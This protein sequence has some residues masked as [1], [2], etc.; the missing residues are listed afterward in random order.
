HL[1]SKKYEHLMHASEVF[2]G[3]NYQ[4]PEALEALRGSD[5]VSADEMHR[6]LKRWS[7][8]GAALRHELPERID[9]NFSDKVM[10]QLDADSA[11]VPPT[12]SAWVPPIESTRDSDL[13]SML[14]GKWSNP[15]PLSANSEHNVAHEYAALVT[16]LKAQRDAADFNA[17][18]IAAD[19]DQATLNTV[20]HQPTKRHPVLSFKRVGSWLGQAAVAAS[21]AVVAVV[22]VQLYNASQPELDNPVPTS[23]I[24]QV[25]PV[26]GLNLASYQNSDND[27]IMNPELMP[28]QPQVNTPEAQNKDLT[29]AEV[30]AE[31]KAELDRINLYVQGFMLE[32][33]AN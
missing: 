18:H 27:L 3:Q 5:E 33:A 19:F 9:L 25:G 16:N 10:A 6:H 32:T 26:N 7:L 23:A 29:D 24:T 12:E 17:Q 20:P 31:Q 30:R 28:Q 2:D 11:W 13:P 15:G 8:I 21:V 4:N 1:S 14:Q 22:G